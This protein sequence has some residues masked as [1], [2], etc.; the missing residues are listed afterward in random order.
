MNKI[1]IHGTLYDLREF[2]HPGGQEILELCKHEPDCSALFESY[3]AFSDMKK[4]KTILKKYEVGSTEKPS[5]FSFKEDGF[6]N[7][8][9]RRVA[10]YL[11]DQSKK[12]S[13]TYLGTVL[14]SIGLFGLSQYL[15]F[16]TESILVKS[17]SSFTSGCA[18]MMLGY[19]ILHDGSHFAISTYP[20]VNKILSSCIHTIT[21]SNYTLWGY[22]HVIRHHQYTGMIEYDPDIRNTRPLFRKTTK[23][24]QSKHEVSDTYISFKVILFNVFLPGVSLGQ[25]LTYLLWIKRNYVWKMNLPDIFGQ[26]QDIVQYSLSLLYILFY[27]TYAGFPYFYGYALGLN[28][29]YW[30]GSAP[31]HDMY[32][33]H[34]QIEQHDKLIDWGEMQVRHSGNFMESYP[35]FTRFMGGINYQI[36]HHLFPS[37]SNHK[38]KEIAPIVKQTCK[39]FTIPY[40]TV[41]SPVQVLN[42]VFKTYKEVHSSKTN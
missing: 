15:T 29:V 35:L 40:H 21:F 11:G 33:T 38:L 36:E 4:I 12:W 1:P 42:E 27:I 32:D 31:D 25:S 28:L 18:S 17:L 37:L 5:M 9:K 14:S 8:L 34:K 39:E 41:D 2:N 13:Y 19:N 6:Y 22:H 7:T 3:H 20:K 10:T 26:T 16:T 24:P 30:I 23:L